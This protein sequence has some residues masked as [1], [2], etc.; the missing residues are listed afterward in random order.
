[1]RFAG[2]GGNHIDI[3]TAWTWW[4]GELKEL[5]RSLRNSRHFSLRRY[6][7]IV[8]GTDGGEIADIDCGSQAERKRRLVRVC[9]SAPELIEAVVKGKSR[10]PLV[11]RLR[12]EDCLIRRVSVPR[13]ALFRLDKILGLEIG[14]MTPFAPSQVLS[15]WYELPDESL[16]EHASIAHVIVRKDLVSPIV[17]RLHERGKRIARIEVSSAGDE[18]LPVDLSASLAL[19]EPPGVRRWRRLSL[20][21]AMAAVGLALLAGGIVLSRQAAEIALLDERLG[22]VQAE[23]RK[24][25]DEVDAIEGSSQRIA[26]L[27]K[28]KLGSPSPLAV[29]SELTRLLPD[30]AWLAGLSINETGVTLDGTAQSAE[31]LIT[32]LDGSPLFEKVAFTGPV[33]KMPGGKLD[34]FSISLTLS[35]PASLLGLATR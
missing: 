4:T 5:A 34:R 28:E 12:A 19:A 22:Q 29:W 13:S 1:V 31:D 32:T 9:T 15:G 23:A 21:A 16:G 3:G 35:K 2:R 11:L 27:R 26:G 7:E 30:T 10:R 14:R 8:V 24:V 18:T 17:E 33:T 25:R 6:R 20:S